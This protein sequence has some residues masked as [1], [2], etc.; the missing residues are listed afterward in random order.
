MRSAVSRSYKSVLKSHDERQTPSRSTM[1]KCK[2]KMAP[3]EREGTAV[4]VSAPKA[5]GLTKSRWCVK[6]T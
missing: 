1:K 4:S 2:S 6:F 5:T 3:G